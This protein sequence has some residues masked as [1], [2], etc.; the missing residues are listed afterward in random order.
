MDMKHELRGATLASVAI[1]ILMAIVSIAG[2]TVRLRGSYGN[3]STALGPTASTAG[4]LIPGFLGQD[5]FNLLVGVPVLVGAVWLTHRG[6]ELAL[7]LWPG[8][9]LYTLYTYAIY[10]IGAPFSG[11]FPAYALLVALTGFTIITL[12]TVIDH[13]RVRERL[14]PAVPARRVGGL[15]I[16]LALLTIAQDA[17][18]AITT[19][20]SG[21]APDDPLARAVWSVDLSIEA[22]VVL[23][24]GVLLWLRRPI[25]YFAGAGLLL[26]YG[27]TP[28]ALA[29]GLL[30]RGIV[31]GFAIDWGGV[32]GVLVFAVVSFAPLALFVRNAG[33]HTV[34]PQSSERRV[35][36]SPSRV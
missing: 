28:V 23:V 3:P 12:V 33:T 11:L 5:A 22:P 25:G 24:G 13:R 20:V 6:S 17:S 36:A 32:A 35:A 10:M 21:A 16:G 7:L 30:L 18:G 26:Q 9:L 4:I 2:L 31:T 1:G 19:A 27:L 14:Q 8:A 15:L 29:F 34:G